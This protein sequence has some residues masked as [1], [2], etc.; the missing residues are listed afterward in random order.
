ML[1]NVGMDRHFW[2]KAA[3]TTC[4]SINRSPSIALNNKTPIEVWSGTP[5]DY[6]Q[7]KV[8]GCTA[9]AHVDN[10]KLEPRA[11]KCVFLGYGSRVKEYK[12]WNPKT[13]KAMLSRS[14]VFN[15]SKMHYAN[16]SYNVQSSV[17]HKVSMLVENLDEDDHMFQDAA[18]PDLQ[19][20]D[21]SPI[22][23]YCLSTEHSSHVV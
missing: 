14:V 21:I 3:S 20:H 15:E 18:I 17:P 16:H 11:A 19:V 7:I 9:Y 22:I 12:L 1:F 13:K 23:D 2:A 8:F 5:S 6:S 10:G 4:Y